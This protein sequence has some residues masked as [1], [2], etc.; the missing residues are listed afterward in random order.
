[1]WYSHTIEYYAAIKL[2]LWRAFNELKKMPIKWYSVEWKRA[3]KI[4]CT[5][6]SQLFNHTYSFKNAGKKDAEI[7]I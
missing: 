5:V 3:C 1:M 4:L 6:W 2:C 7:L